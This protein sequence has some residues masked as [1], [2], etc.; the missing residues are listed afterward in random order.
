MT[1]EHGLYPSTVG[2]QLRSVAV[3]KP[4]EHEVH[5]TQSKNLKFKMF[6]LLLLSGKSLECNFF[7]ISYLQDIILYY[8][9]RR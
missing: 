6:L 1:L 2:I 4:L 9:G 3:S 7:S 8:S 5:R